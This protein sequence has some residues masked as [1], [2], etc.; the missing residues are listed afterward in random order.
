MQDRQSE[1]TIVLSIVRKLLLSAW[2]LNSLLICYLSYVSAL[3]PLVYLWFIWPS[4]AAT[5]MLMKIR[6]RHF[7]INIVLLLIVLG[8]VAYEAAGPYGLVMML[9]QIGSSL[10]TALC[11]VLI[12]GIGIAS[13]IATPVS[14]SSDDED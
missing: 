8:R 11:I 10:D 12:L 7:V 2:Y 13:V 5:L 1:R 6:G 9:S 3:F 14:D 4:L